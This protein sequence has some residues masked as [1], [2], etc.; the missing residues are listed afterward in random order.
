MT[1]S[2]KREVSDYQ[3][4]PEQSSKASDGSLGSQEV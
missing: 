1:S 3:P 4:I 2:T